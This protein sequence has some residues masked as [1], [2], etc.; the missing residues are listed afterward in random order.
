[1]RHEPEGR[2]AGRQE[3]GISPFHQLSP[4]TTFLWTLIYFLTASFHT[5][6]EKKTPA[7]LFEKQNSPPPFSQLSATTC[8]I[9]LLF[10]ANVIPSRL[11]PGSLT[12]SLYSPVVVSTSIQLSAGGGAWL[13]NGSYA[14][15]GVSSMGPKIIG[16]S[17]AGY[18]AIPE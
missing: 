13:R 1:M 2:D 11:N 8:N 4:L 12:F 10:V 14:L 5:T 17:G 3:I 18:D 9:R 7:D 15:C 16:G 6:K